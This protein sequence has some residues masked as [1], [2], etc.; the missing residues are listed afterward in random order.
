MLL[1]LGLLGLLLDLILLLVTDF[2]HQ[3]LDIIIVYLREMSLRFTF[4]VLAVFY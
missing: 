3:R 4:N 1:L 2:G